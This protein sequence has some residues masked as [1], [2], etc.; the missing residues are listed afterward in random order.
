MKFSTN[1]NLAYVSY[2]QGGKKDFKDLKGLTG[3]PLPGQQQFER[4]PSHLHIWHSHLGLYLAAV[5]TGRQ[6][7]TR[8]QGAC[9]SHQKTTGQEKWLFP[10]GRK[11]EAWRCG[12]GETLLIFSSHGGL[13]TSHMTTAV[14]VVSR[15]TGVV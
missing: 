7:E 6:E 15:T 11:G 14:E 1:L 8:E 5:E 9:V 4:M 13:C 3:V 10:G 12:R 2:I